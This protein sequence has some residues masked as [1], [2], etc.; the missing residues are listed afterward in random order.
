MTDETMFERRLANALGRFAL[1]APPMDDEL[2]AVTAIELGGR[3]KLGRLG[4]L[5][6]TLFAPRPWGRGMRPG[7]LLVFLA[8][9]LAAIVVA[10][11]GGFVRR[12]SPLVTGRNGSIV[13]S[14]GPNGHQAVQN[15]AID[16]DGQG[17]HQV[18][19]G[20]CP[21]YSHDG[22]ALAW[23]SY[24]DAGAFLLVADMGGGGPRKSL[25]VESA[26][27]SVAFDLSPD[28]SR[29]AWLRPTSQDPTATELF[30]GPT[31]GSAGT[32]I[33]AAPSGPG[34][35]Y[36]SL[37][38]SPD[39]RSI[40]FATYRRDTATG[41]SRRTAIEVVGVDG[42]DRRSV[43]TRPGPEDVLSWSPDSRSIAYVGSSDGVDS[44]TDDVFVIGIDGMGD[45][46]LTTSSSTP[47][48]PAWSPDGGYLAFLVSGDG[49]TARLATLPLAA[50]TSAPPV[51]GPSSEWFIWSPDG[52]ELL[53]AQVLAV[54]AETN[55]TNLFS[56][57]RELRG[58][59]VTRQVVDGLIVCTPSWQRLRP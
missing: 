14:V 35:S 21:V 32:R 49:Q 10:T 44:S 53:S 56:I 16:A 47:R 31:D 36:G 55:R 18:D 22:N 28:G 27:R 20:R 2:V 57:D 59:P 46:R 7:Y 24:E 42:S 23:L 33:A 3:P 41:G 54:D 15:V 40:V 48:A 12:E 30:V 38:W 19:A 58:P 1:L 34:E 51:S 52:S 43:T 29:V 26:Q 13:Y 45:H 6:E 50:P 17:L 25:L 11:V 8:L 5:A 9:L 4:Q 37:S 39:G